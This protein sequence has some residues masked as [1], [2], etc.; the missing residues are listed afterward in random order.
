ME[1][2]TLCDCD[3]I[4]RTYATHCKKKVNHTPQVVQCERVFI[5]LINVP[6]MHMEYKRWK[7]HRDVDWDVKLYLRT[8]GEWIIRNK[9]EFTSQ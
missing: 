4:T 9:H 5:L 6:K 2:F 1:V 8:D 7:W 3:S